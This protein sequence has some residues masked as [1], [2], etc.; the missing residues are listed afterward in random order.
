MKKTL[1]SLMTTL[2]FITHSV[3]ATCSTPTAPDAPSAKPKLPSCMLN[4]KSTDTHD[5]SSSEVENYIDLINDYMKKLNAYAAD[6]I[7]YANSVQQFAK[8]S[9]E[10]AKEGLK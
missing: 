10:E 9:A 2:L 8:C 6:A 5:C 4:Y 7:T 1:A 3:Y